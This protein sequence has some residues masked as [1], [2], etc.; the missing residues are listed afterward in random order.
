MG[1]KPKEVLM[2]V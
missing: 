1:D 2:V